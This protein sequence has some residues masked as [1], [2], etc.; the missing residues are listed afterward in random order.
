MALAPRVFIIGKKIKSDFV[1][2]TIIYYEQIFPLLGKY[3]IN[4]LM[5]IT[6]G[7]FTKLKDILG[8]NDAYIS[9][10]SKFKAPAIF[11]ELHKKGLS[12]RVMYTTFNC[13]MGFIIS[14]PE[15][16][17][18]AVR[19]KLKKSFIIGSVS[20]GSGK[21]KIESAFDKKIVEF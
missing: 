12:N 18:K 7:A 9:F 4:G 17:V 1:R 15:N 10:P 3:K 2:P 16:Q 8:A 20:R 14:V 11:Y 21:I 5:H 6:G 13:G 19:S